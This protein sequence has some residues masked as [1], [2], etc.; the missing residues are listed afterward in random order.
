MNAFVYQKELTISLVDRKRRQDLALT[1]PAKAPT[2]VQSIKH[3][4]NRADQ[5]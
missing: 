1:A 4:I 2:R 5:V 3:A